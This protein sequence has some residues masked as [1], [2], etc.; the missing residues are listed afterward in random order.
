VGNINEVW[1]RIAIYVRDT[2][3]EI[4]RESRSSMPKNEKT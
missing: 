3:K 1:N 4:V 2:A